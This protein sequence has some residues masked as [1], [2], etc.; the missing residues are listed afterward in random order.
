MTEWP[1]FVLGCRDAT[2]VPDFDEL[3]VRLC[4]VERVYRRGEVSVPLV[5]VDPPLNDVGTDEEYRLVL[6]WPRYQGD[7]L[8][9]LR[10]PGW[11]GG[12]LGK[13]IRVNV[14]IPKPGFPF[15][16]DEVEFGHVRSL[17]IAEAALEEADLPPHPEHV[18]GEY[19]AQLLEAAE[20]EGS[21]EFPPGHEL[22]FFAH[23]L[24]ESRLCGD[25]SPELET[26]LGALPGWFWYEGDGL[27]Y[28]ERYATREGNVDVPVDHYEG[29]FPLGLSVRSMKDSAA[30]EIAYGKL[31]MGHPGMFMSAEKMERL[32]GLPGW[33]D[34]SA[35]PPEV[36]LDRL[37]EPIREFIRMTEELTRRRDED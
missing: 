10:D 37:D 27:V 21:A 26:K 2:P 8:E 34:Y 14:G 6:L 17:V 19:L 24:R 20:E 4:R 9:S 13:Y 33:P 28:L 36:I 25:M 32:Q 35:D 5:H 23:S 11:V 15:E 29:G 22:H 30:K 1:E 12:R 7:V 16:S 18:F 31:G 3:G